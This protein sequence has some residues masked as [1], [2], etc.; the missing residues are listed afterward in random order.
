MKKRVPL[1]KTVSVVNKR[2]KK[3]GLFFFRTH[4]PVL[5]FGGLF[6]R[7]TF[8]FAYYSAENSLQ[9][10]MDKTRVMSQLLL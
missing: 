2:H 7:G 9:S 3:A 6:V 4:E 8:F 5:C 1:S 10:L